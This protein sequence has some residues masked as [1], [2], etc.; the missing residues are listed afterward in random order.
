MKLKLVYRYPINLK[1]GNFNFVAPLINDDD[2]VSLMCNVATKFPP[3]Y[4]IKMYV[5]ILPIEMESIDC[6]RL[7]I[8]VLPDP[9]QKM[10]SVDNALEMD[11]KDDDESISKIDSNVVQDMVMNE[12]YVYEAPGNHDVKDN[13]VEIFAYAPTP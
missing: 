11:E 5:E 1:D 2:D 12:G 7:G 4:T 13:D 10:V 9:S 8:G 6:T 3:P